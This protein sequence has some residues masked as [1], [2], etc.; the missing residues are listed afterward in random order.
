MG[1]F[2]SFVGFVGFIVAVIALVR[3]HMDWARLATRKAGGLALAASLVVMVVGGALSPTSTKQ[4]TTVAAEPSPAAA[5]PSPSAESA[6]SDSPSLEAAAG[7]PEPTSTA[8]ISTAGLVAPSGVKSACRSGNPLANVYHPYRLQVVSACATVSGTV[9]AVRREG[10]GDVHFNLEL[11]KQFEGMLTSGNYDYQTGRLVVEIV[12]ADGTSCVKGEPP[13]PAEGTYNYGVC[14]GARVTTPSLGARVYV[15]GPYALDRVHGWAEIHPAWSVST[16]MPAT[17]APAPVV[18][19]KPQQTAQSAPSK[20][21]AP[22]GSPVICRAQM[23]NSSPSQYSTTDVI[24]QTGAAGAQV[25]ATAH[26]KTTN[27]TNTGVSGSNAVADI[28]FRISRATKGYTVT[29]DVTV[30]LS[31]QSASCSTSFTPQ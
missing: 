21:A 5:S 30:S 14:T 12:P 29:V 20:A 8:A 23:S 1:S 15:T 18:A 3:G 4:V 22:T 11:D 24:V 31:G 19:A 2:V 17:P 26:Y 7:E 9:R 28:P 25:S 13:R 6:P 27:T 10:D 16:S